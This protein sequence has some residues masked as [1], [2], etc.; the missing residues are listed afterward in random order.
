MKFWIFAVLIGSLSGISSGQDGPT[1]SGT[2]I[3]LET[4]ASRPDTREIWGKEVGRM[5][6][7]KTGAAFTVL[8][9]EIQRDQTD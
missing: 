1:A 9:I 8:A 4:L 3:S 2:S 6:S 7:G 5:D